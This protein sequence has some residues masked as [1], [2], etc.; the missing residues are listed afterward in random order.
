MIVAE[1]GEAWPFEADITSEEAFQRSFDVNLKGMWLTCKG[2]WHD[3]S[4]FSLD[5]IGLAEH[6]IARP[7]GIPRRVDIQG[8]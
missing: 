7:A 5:L 8:D 2:S 6:R 3:T 4:K 1:G